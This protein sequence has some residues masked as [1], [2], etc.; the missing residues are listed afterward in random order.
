MRQLARFLD[1]GIWEPRLKN[2]STFHAIVI[3]YMRII[4]L[5]SRNFSRNDSIRTASVLTYYS[6]LNFVPLIA[7]IFAIAKGFGL[8]RMIEAYTIQVADTAHLE[9]EM[10]NQIIIFSN[11]L[12]KHARGGV[13]AGVGI[14]LLLWTVISILGKIEDSFN[15]IWEVKRARTL[16]RK[17]SDYMSILFVVPI[18]FAVSASATMVAASQIKMITREISFLGSLSSGAI[19]LIGLLPYIS[20]W[21]LLILL[22]IVMP[23]TRV[24]IRSGLLAGLIAGTGFQIIQ[25]V[26][27]K[28][29]TGISS[30]G[31]IYGSFAAIPLF[32]G[33]LQ[34]SWIIV[35]FGAEIA[36]AAEYSDTFGFYPDYLKIGSASRRLFM[37]KVFHLTAKRFQYGEK[38]LNARQIAD[39][40]RMPAKLVEDSLGILREI[41]LI[42]EAVDEKRNNV[43]QPAKPVDNM[44]IQDVLDAYDRSGDEPPPLRS[45][46]EQRKYDEQIRQILSAM[47]GG[48]KIRIRDL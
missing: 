31:G 32:L 17:F 27:L 42:I 48:E 13:I 40:L 30:Y 22:Y 36:H 24:S 8:R 2:L 47:D 3:R 29:Q 9:P 25:F 4:I 44:T 19:F 20:I 1:K 21:A 28:L 14:I 39:R 15:S 11:S 45:N 12:L 41:G 5:A 38:P 16:I 10:A 37:L 7:V 43:F 26:Y 35:L 23:N 6:V 18:L 34:T 33:W 46:D